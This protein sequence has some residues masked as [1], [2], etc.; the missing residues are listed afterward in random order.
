MIVAQTMIT[1]AML[2]KKYRIVIASEDYK[3]SD[4][5]K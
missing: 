4:K 2:I 1:T 5:T 3:K